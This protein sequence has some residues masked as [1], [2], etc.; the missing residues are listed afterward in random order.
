MLTVV[1]LLV[2]SR[3]TLIRRKLICDR[4]PRRR[5]RV[6]GHDFPGR[7]HPSTVAVLTTTATAS[8]TAS[9]A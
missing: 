7:T 1:G 4:S 8:M 5:R 6:D 9:M 3:T 2:Q